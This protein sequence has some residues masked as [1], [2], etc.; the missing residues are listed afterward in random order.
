MSE[1]TKNNSLGLIRVNNN[2]VNKEE[3]QVKI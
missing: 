3:N 1:Q 2:K